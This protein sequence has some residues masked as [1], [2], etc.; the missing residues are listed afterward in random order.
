MGNNISVAASLC[1]DMGELIYKQ[2]AELTALR[3]AAMEVV[4][5]N[6]P[7]TLGK[8]YLSVESLTALL[9]NS[10]EVSE[11]VVGKTLPGSRKP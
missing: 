3:S 5:A 1:V 4:N 11:T 8:L 9:P 7:G 2:Q 10:E 6:K